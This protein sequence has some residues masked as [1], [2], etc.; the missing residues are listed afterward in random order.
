KADTAA[1]IAY[2][3]SEVVAATNSELPEAKVHPSLIRENRW[4]ACRH[5]VQAEII[6]PVTE[7]PVALLL[8]LG[9]RIEWLARHGAD[10]KDLS[11]IEEHLKAWQQHGDGASR[12]RRMFHQTDDLNSV[13]QGM[14][15]EDGWS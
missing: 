5:G 14:Y 13:V 4:R 11:I 6:D 3:R 10:P 1:Y 15:Q 9:R 8:W 7:E 12:Q 2:V